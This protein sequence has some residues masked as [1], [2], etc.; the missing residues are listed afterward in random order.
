M[1]DLK[2]RKRELRE[3]MAKEV[4]FN[5][6]AMPIA[7]EYQQVDDYFVDA[8]SPA[9]GIGGEE[10]TIGTELSEVIYETIME[11]RASS[12]CEDAK[13]VCGLAKK[14]TGDYSVLSVKD[15]FIFTCGIKYAHMIQ[16]MKRMAAEKKVEN[17]TAAGD[18]I[19][20]L[21]SLVEELK[22]GDEKERDKYV[23]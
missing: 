8:V 18:L 14:L 2:L 21:A 4:Y 13:K 10:G 17:T 9:I 6:P 1:K 22:S 3:R 16:K 7:P 5:E 11:D 23:S 19:R 12:F 15:M 20:T